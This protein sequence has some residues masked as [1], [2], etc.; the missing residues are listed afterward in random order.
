MK[1]S[2][3]QI[4][5]AIETLQRAVPDKTINCG[6]FCQFCKTQNVHYGINKGNYTY[7]CLKCQKQIYSTEV[8]TALK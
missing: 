7:E 5:N 6:G 3:R 4:N 1:L 2:K 8:L